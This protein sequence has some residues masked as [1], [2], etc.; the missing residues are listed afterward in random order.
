MEKKKLLKKIR[1]SALA[2]ELGKSSKELIEILKDLGIAVKTHASSVDAEAVKVVT[3]LLTK[4]KEKTKEAVEEEEKKAEEPPKAEIVEDPVIEEKV[5]KITGES[6]AIKELSNLLNINPS[7]VIKELMKKGFLLNINQNVT[8]DLAAQIVEKFGLKAEVVKAIEKQH[9]VILSDKHEL[10]DRPPVVAIMGHVDHGKTKLLDAIRETKVAESEAGGITQ[11]IGAYQVDIKGKKITFLDTP[12]HEAFTALRARGAKV[13]DIA[14]LVVAAD[15]GVMPQTIEAIDHAKAAGV[16]IIV[17]INKIDKADAS[18]EKVKQQL[19]EYKLIAEDWGGETVMVAISA[20]QGQNIDELL[21]MI[22]LVSDVQELKANPDVPAQG[23]VVESKLDK[24]RGSVATVLIKNGT[25]RVGDPIV[26]GSVYGKVRALITE[27]GERLKTAP[28]SAAVEVLG[29]SEVPQPGEL[30]QAVKSEKEAR[31]LASKKN[32]ESNL[33]HR[34][35]QTL[36]SFSQHIKEGEKTDL[37]VIVKADVRGSLEALVQS[38]RDLDVSGIH[39]NVIHSQAG[40]VLESD[41]LLAEAS[42]AII[43]GFHANVQPRAIELA[44]AEGVSI[45]RYD[46]IYKVIEDIKLAMEG[47]LSTVYEEVI[48]GEG[49]V[50]AT[51]KYSKVGVIAGTF[52]SSGKFVRGSGLRVL[53]GEKL[54]YENK[55]ESLKRFKDDVKEVLEGFECGV[56]IRGFT[57]FKEGD[58][59]QIFEMREKNK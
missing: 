51:F 57:D 45:R 28:P 47:M 7:E 44:K 50:R 9:K 3:E 11:H 56:A 22:L 43:V 25:L 26:I 13:T 41:V 15:D 53:R 23:V 30:L 31:L 21:E 59:I 2:K 33:A 18:P 48:I 37:N 54:V 52:I 1:V 36:E 46:V 20:K 27:F 55:L 5:I 42:G 35:A 19:S 38:L 16:P 29:L 14:V 34:A 49:E 8:S 10:K 17:A 40:E 12:G 4:P 39:V 6:I 32:E 24:G 58:K